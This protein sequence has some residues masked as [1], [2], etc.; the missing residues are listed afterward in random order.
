VD[1]FSQIYVKIGIGQLSQKCENC[2]TLVNTLEWLS[3]QTIAPLL[4]L[5]Q[6]T[7]HFS[8][9]IDDGAITKRNWTQFHTSFMLNI[10]HTNNIV[11][12]KRFIMHD[13]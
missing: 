11:Y 8:F 1:S 10:L 3:M 13:D 5:S 9:S 7:H 4:K 2:P 6:D 12:S